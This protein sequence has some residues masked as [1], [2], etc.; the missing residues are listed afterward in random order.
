MHPQTRATYTH[1]AKCRDRAPSSSSWCAVSLGADCLPRSD[2]CAIHDWR[3]WGEPRSGRDGR[4]PWESNIYPC[5][6]RPALPRAHLCTARRSGVANH[7]W[8]RI[9]VITTP[10]SP[11]RASAR[12]QGQ[13][14]CRACFSSSKC[15]FHRPARIAAALLA[16][17]FCSAIFCTAAPKAGGSSPR[18]EL[19]HTKKRPH[20]L[21]L[22]VSNPPT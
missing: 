13:S 1:I 5:F 16:P 2:G 20:N 17:Q 8:R 12:A 3:L 15:P 21:P 9:V 18:G 7:L 6:T 11:L 19:H 4:S 22:F 10:P 14:A